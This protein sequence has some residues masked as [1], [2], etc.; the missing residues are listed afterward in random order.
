MNKEIHAAVHKQLHCMTTTVYMT[1]LVRFRNRFNNSSVLN[2]CL[3]ETQAIRLS[4]LAVLIRNQ[5][6][7]A[8]NHSMT[9]LPVKMT[10]KAVFFIY[11]FES[12][13]FLEDMCT[14]VNVLSSTWASIR[15]EQ[16][17]ASQTRDIC[18]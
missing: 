15:R 6:P 4:L 17:R 11:G 8:L 16:R 7:G 5:F 2:I 12:V 1:T 18:E 9:S 10:K 13:L 14:L 3:Y